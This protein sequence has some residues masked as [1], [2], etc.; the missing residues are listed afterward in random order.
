VYRYIGVLQRYMCTEIV[1]CYSGTCIVSV[2]KGTVQEQYRGTM[3]TG[4]VQ[5]YRNSTVVQG[6][7]STTGLLE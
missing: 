6:Y 7:R 2:C 5:A 4:I 1:E 3:R